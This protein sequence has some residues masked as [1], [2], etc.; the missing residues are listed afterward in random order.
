[1]F[2][3]PLAVARG[4]LAVAWNVERRVRHGLGNR[5]RKGLDNLLAVARRFLAVARR[6]NPDLTA[7]PIVVHVVHQ[8]PRFAIVV[9][10]IAGGRLPPGL[11]V[12]QGRLLV[13]R[14]KDLG[15]AGDVVR[16]DQLRFGS[17]ARFKVRKGS[18]L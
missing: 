17:L 2:H 8:V 4:I 7:F 1:M 3:N 11:I 18:C 13:V 14:L 10:L 12:L 15:G 5:R 16:G 6:S 9:V